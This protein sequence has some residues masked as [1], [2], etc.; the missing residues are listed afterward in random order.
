MQR[1]VKSVDYFQTQEIV[2]AEGDV[3]YRLKNL[4]DFV[5]AL[6]IIYAGTAS[7]DAGTRP[8]MIDALLENISQMRR[9][10]KL[11]SLLK[12]CPDLGAE[13]IG[14]PNLQCE[15]EGVWYCTYKQCADC[16]PVCGRCLFH[17]HAPLW[18]NYNSLGHLRCPYCKARRAIECMN[19]R[20]E[21]A[22]SSTQ[23]RERLKR[24]LGDAPSEASS[25]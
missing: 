13:I 1:I 23:E 6:R 5:D 14:H 18:G 22:W 2:T 8:L 15:A 12:E 4:D 9:E 17:Y 20:G 19:C 3:E 7:E 24:S 10:D 25:E 21:A 16:V 11:L